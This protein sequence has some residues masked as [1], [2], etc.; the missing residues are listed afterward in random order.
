MNNLLKF[1]FS[2]HDLL[3]PRKSN[4]EFSCYKQAAKHHH[5]HP[6]HQHMPRIQSSTLNFYKSPLFLFRFPDAITDSSHVSLHVLKWK[7]FSFFLVLLFSSTV[8]ENVAAG[9]GHQ[10][11]FVIDLEGNFKFI[12]KQRTSVVDTVEY[13]NVFSFRFFGSMKL[14]S[15]REKKGRRRRKFYANK[16]NIFRFSFALVN[17]I[18]SVGYAYFACEITKLWSERYIWIH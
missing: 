6:T 8:M 18:I 13:E 9:F 17:I 15:I 4:S 11:K 2:F 12:E 10:W 1:K 7:V 14:C 16:L 3:T 5:P